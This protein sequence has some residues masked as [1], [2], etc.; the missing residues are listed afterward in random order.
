MALIAIREGIDILALAAPQIRR[1]AA[2]GTHKGD[3]QLVARR[4]FAILRPHHMARDDLE[5]S[6][7]GGGEEE[8]AA[9]GIEGRIGGLFH[10]GRL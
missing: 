7:A 2:R 9:G 8:A 10:G 3:V 5:G 4:L 1:P 6:R